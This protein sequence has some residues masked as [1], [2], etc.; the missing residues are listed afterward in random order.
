M[1]AVVI[2]VVVGLAGAACGHGGGTSAEPAVAVS[3]TAPATTAAAPVPTS[4]ADGSSST[5]TASRPPATLTPTPVKAAA[6]PTTASTGST[7]GPGPAPAPHAT[8][9]VAAAPT[10][11][12]GLD[13]LADQLAADETALRNPATPVADIPALARRQQAAYRA[14]SARPDVLPRVLARLPENLR[15]IA[16][17]NVDAGAELR[18]MTT[19]KTDLPP[20]RILTPPPADEL[21]RDYHEAEA[22]THVPWAYLAAVHLVETRMGRIRGTSTAGAQGPMQFLPSTWARW[23]G[24]GDINDPHDAIMAAGRYLAASGAPADLHKALY[25]YNHSEHYVRAVTL[26]AQQIEADPRA[27]LAY[28]EW[29]VYY[30]TPRGDLWLEE[31]YGG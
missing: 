1:R 25:A 6:S 11:P 27:Y 13:R 31:G 24:G 4:A 3:T 20:W 26:Y 16:Q 30:I 21:E 2:A 14:L 7:T 10:D 29:Q 5:S 22:A 28:H 17:A 15:P 19:P 12:A 8:V 9:F 23:G 18:A